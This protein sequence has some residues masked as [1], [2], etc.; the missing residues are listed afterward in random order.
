MANGG[1]V[2]TD[3]DTASPITLNGT[4]PE[5]AG[6]P[7]AGQNLTFFIQVLPDN[8]TLSFT[9]TNSSVNY[10][11]NGNFSGT[12]SFTFTAR[13][14]ANNNSTA[15][16]T[17][18]ITISEV[19]DLPVANNQTLATNEDV[20]LDITL[21]GSDPVEG[22]PL[23]FVVN[24]QPKNGTL[25]GSNS[26]WTY[27]P[28]PNFNG[29][30]SFTF[31]VNDGTD[32]SAAAAVSIAVNPVAEPDDDDDDDDSR[33]SGGGGGKRVVI[34]NN[35]N[36]QGGSSSV[37]TYPESYFAD[38]P[39]Y[40]IG[41]SNSS[42]FDAFGVSVD[43]AAIGQQVRITG[44][45]SNHQQAAQDYAFIVQITDGDGV[46]IFFGF[47][48]GNIE[49]GNTADISLTWTPEAAGDYTVK[50]F[51]WDGLQPPAQPLSTVTAMNIEVTG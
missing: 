7:F 27:T 35:N 39:L 28:H 3:E 13:D 18:L 26:S 50:I 44:T 38:N 8:G 29:V 37:T 24:T 51:V 5:V 2:T 48:N 43:V 21:T 46:V 17:V 34:I 22:S 9:G 30:D 11:P 49:S 41:V 1:S 4:N 23:T 47:Q 15:A 33:R 31:V 16:A 36:N 25:V 42:L 6:N 12:D 40:R 20:P 32:D 19:N 10:T 14:T 45:L